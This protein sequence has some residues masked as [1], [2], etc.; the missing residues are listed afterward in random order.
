MTESAKGAYAVFF[1]YVLW[2]ILPVYWRALASVDSMEILAHRALWSCAFALCLAALTRR[3]GEFTLLF[4]SRRALGMLAFSSLTVSANWCIY[5]WAVNDGRILE[6]SLGYFINPL[7]S[8][9]FGVV[10]FKEHLGKLQRLA[11]VLAAA[12]VCAEVLSLGRLPLVSLGIA[13]T[14][15]LYGLLKK[16]SRAESLVGFAAET[17]LITPFALWWLVWRQQAGLAHFPYD[18]R[19]TFLLI[20]AGVVTAV[21]LILFAWGVKRTTMTTVGV[22]QYTS[23]ILMFLTATL[24]YHE[25]MPPARWLS[26]LLIWASLL[27]FTKAQKP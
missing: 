21:P 4:R 11:V 25:P 9:L 22:T 7:V 13:F 24:L 12:G 18:P 8:I 19:R 15:G 5:I 14:F 16:M 10:F 27:L 3:W 23:P 26:F 17:L 2:G 20:G 1:T 6:S